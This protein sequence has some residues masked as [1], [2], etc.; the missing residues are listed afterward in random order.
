VVH[1]RQ[2]FLGEHELYH[3]STGSNFSWSRT[4]NESKY[5]GVAPAIPWSQ[6]R[7]RVKAMTS[8]LESA[9]TAIGESAQVHLSST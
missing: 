8:G 5:S 6:V 3:C 7:L 4:L 1:I 9:W 2:T